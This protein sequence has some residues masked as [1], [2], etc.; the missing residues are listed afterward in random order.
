LIVFNFGGL[1]NIAS[2]MS[3]AQQIPGKMQELNEQLKIEMVQATAGDGAVLVTI[4]CIGQ[5]QSVQVEPDARHHP[6]L[7]IWI[8][9][10]S[11]AAASEA[12]QRYAESVSQMAKDMKLNIPGLDGMLAKLTSGA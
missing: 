1:G 7:E 8:V 9:E 12:K 4:N 2:L 11:N 5:M 6:E 3:S 10:A